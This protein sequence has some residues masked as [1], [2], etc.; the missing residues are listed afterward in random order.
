MLARVAERLA[1]EAGPEDV[2]R[3]H[4]RILQARQVWKD[5][6]RREVVSEHVLDLKSKTRKANC[7]FNA[8]P[9]LESRARLSRQCV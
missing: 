6:R 7:L 5:R 4:L 3:W 9:P 2:A 8:A 1:R